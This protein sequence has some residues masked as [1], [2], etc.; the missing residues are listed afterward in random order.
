MR[1]YQCLECRE[2]ESVAYAVS[3]DERILYCVCRNCAE[4][5]IVGDC[6]DDDR[7][8]ANVNDVW[9]VEE[10]ELLCRRSGDKKVCQCK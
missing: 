1:K 9:F 7:L 3:N 8:L 5:M 4:P 2:V 10:R 6:T